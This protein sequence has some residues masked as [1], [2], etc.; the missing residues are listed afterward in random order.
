MID[1]VSA[2][3]TCTT[4]LAHFAALH[5]LL[6]VLPLRDVATTRVPSSSEFEHE[7]GSQTHAVKIK[8]S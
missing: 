7:I 1:G 4:F 6:P 8:W 3:A 5:V 2:V